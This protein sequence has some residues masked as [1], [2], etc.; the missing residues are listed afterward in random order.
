MKNNVKLR[1]ALLGVSFFSFG[2]LQAQEASDDSADVWAAVEAA[3]EAD[4]KGDKKWVDNMLTDDFTGWSKGSPAPRS[5]DSTKMWDRFSE[6]Q[7]K[8]V[9]HELYPL[10]IVI[11]ADIAI[12]HYLYT[13]AYDDKKDGV[14]M[15]NGRYTDILVRTADGWKFIA[16][17]GGDDE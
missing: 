14:E 17:H 4:E 9:A 1:I 15:S 3:W 16:W 6:Q 8:S 7:G 13:N 5:K 11:H 12:A 10:S 2:M